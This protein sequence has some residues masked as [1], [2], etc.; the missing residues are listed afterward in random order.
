MCHF[1]WEH[2]DGSPPPEAELDTIFSSVGSGVGASVG[3]TVVG[4]FVGGFVGSET[5][6]SGV[7]SPAE[8]SSLRVQSLP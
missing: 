3:A 1:F 4:A 2:D 8:H 7:A 6:L 5:V